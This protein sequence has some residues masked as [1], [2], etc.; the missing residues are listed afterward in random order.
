MVAGTLM[1]LVAKLALLPGDP[2]FWGMG[3]AI[4]LVALG[5]KKR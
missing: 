4:L 5:W 3:V 2:V 1:M